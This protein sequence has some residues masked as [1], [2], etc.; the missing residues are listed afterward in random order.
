METNKKYYMKTD[1]AYF[2]GLTLFLLT[3]VV[4]VRDVLRPDA[5]T[6][7]LVISYALILLFGTFSI[8]IIVLIIQIFRKVSYIELT[9]TEITFNTLFNKTTTQKLKTK[10]EYTS[11]RG[12]LQTIK[13]FDKDHKTPTIMLSDVYSVPLEDIKKKIEQLKTTKNR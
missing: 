3:F 1:I 2:I 11:K 12:K 9:E 13:L 10:I 5:T 7:N 4:S 6:L 8:I